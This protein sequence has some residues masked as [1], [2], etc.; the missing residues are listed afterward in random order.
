M[1]LIVNKLSQQ[2]LRSGTRFCVGRYAY[3]KTIAST[4]TAAAGRYE[5]GSKINR[6]SHVLHLRHV[7][8]GLSALKLVGFLYLTS[9]VPGA[10]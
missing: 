10:K 7:V 3:T 5:R 1:Y 2:D 9:F 4:P 8:A 6:T